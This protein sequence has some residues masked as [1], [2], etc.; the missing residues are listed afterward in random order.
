MP[1]LILIKKGN[2]MNIILYIILF[3][4]GVSCGCFYKVAIYKIPKN[5]DLLK[6]HSYYHNSNEKKGLKQMMSVLTYMLIGG[7][8]FVVIA[9]TLEL[10]IYST[11]SIIIYVLTLLY[12]STIII[13]SG[14]DKEYVK[15]EKKTLS[16]GTIVSLIYIIFLCAIDST[17]IYR[18]V[19]YLGIHIILLTL[20]TF[21]LRRYAKNSYTIDML[22]LLNIILIFSEVEITFYTIIMTILAI[23]INILILKI[24]QK[25]SGNKQIKLNEIPMGFLVG[26]SNLIVIYMFTFITQF[27]QT[28]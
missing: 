14:I 6:K 23:G 10:D 11:S 8:S 20:D 13:I 22:I 12:I 2:E 5:M 16:F 9:K 1:V 25:K 24:R 27:I 19:I 3:L 15:I 26:A 21:L 4:I 18:Y 28:N 17:T 7:T